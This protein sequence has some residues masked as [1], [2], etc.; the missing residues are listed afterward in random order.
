VPHP[1]ARPPIFCY[2]TDRASLDVRAPR[3][4]SESQPTTPELHKIDPL[5]PLLASI[6]AAAA[7][8]VHWIQL[9]EKDLPAKEIARLTRAALS[10]CTKSEDVNSSP[11]QSRIFVNE[12][13]DVAIAER[14]GGVHLGENSLPVAEARRL[15]QSLPDE[16]RPADFLTGASCHSLRSAQAAADAGADYIFFGPVFPTPSKLTYG[17]AQ[18]LQLLTEICRAVSIPVLAIGGIN[19]QNATACVTAGAA[20]V[21]AIRLFQ[22]PQEA[23]NV[24]ALL[25]SLSR[26]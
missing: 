26:G 4:I 18:G 9:R 5:A 14:A 15:L 20:G 22:Q 6:A 23:P 2:V 24:A 25:R 21:A 10:C 1:S 7:A 17:P 11:C 19:A 8:G 12:R 13:L 3:E 16:N